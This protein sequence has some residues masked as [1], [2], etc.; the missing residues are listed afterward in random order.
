MKSFLYRNTVLLVMFNMTS[1]NALFYQEWL[2]LFCLLHTSGAHL[3][4]AE[5]FFH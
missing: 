3:A 2:L 4:V 1:L 5:V